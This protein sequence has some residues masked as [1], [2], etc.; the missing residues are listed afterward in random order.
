MFKCG[1]ADARVKAHIA[2]RA[3]VL[4]AGG[5]CRRL[6]IDECERRQRLA[7]FSGAKALVSDNDRRSCGVPPAPARQAIA[8]LAQEGRERA[9]ESVGSHAAPPP[10]IRRIGNR[11]ISVRTRK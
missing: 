5:D 4:E 7:R 1:L 11:E 6:R 9:V 2:K 3:P 10:L 8:A